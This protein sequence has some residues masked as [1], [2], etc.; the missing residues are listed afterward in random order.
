MAGVIESAFNRELGRKI[1]A[2][3]KQRKICQQDLAREIGAHRNT[4]LRW[5]SGEGAPPM[6]M[7]LRIAD[8]LCCNHLLLL[9]DVGL[10]WGEAI[11]VAHERDSKKD[12]RHALIERDPPLRKEEIA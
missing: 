6:W 12:L 9:P 3:R 7:L 10:T 2:K 5:E 4:L 11:M 1:E 8:V